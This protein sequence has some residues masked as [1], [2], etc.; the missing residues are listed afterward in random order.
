MAAMLHACHPRTSK[1]KDKCR[2]RQV[3]RVRDH[4]GHCQSYST[5]SS[6]IS[7]LKRMGRTQGFCWCYPQI[8]EDTVGKLG[9]S[10]SGGVGSMSLHV[11]GLV[12]SRSLEAKRLSSDGVLS[13]EGHREAG[14]GRG[15]V[16]LETSLN[17][18]P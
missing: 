18:I 9:L 4:P 8:P 10:W 3:E 5:E 14:T 13:G 15:V 7:S 2:R 17:L 11:T 16:L 12:R 1:E 6:H